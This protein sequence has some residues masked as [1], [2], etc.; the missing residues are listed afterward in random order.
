VLFLTCQCQCQCQTIG[1]EVERNNDYSGVGE[2]AAA[3]IVFLAAESLE[4]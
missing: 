3:T 1:I 4:T 2:C